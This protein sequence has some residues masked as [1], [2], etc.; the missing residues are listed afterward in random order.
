MCVYMFVCVC[1]CV[2][3]FQQAETLSFKYMLKLHQY[4][5]KISIFLFEDINNCCK[6]YQN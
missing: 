3:L 1:L 2:I 5:P 4:Y 6:L